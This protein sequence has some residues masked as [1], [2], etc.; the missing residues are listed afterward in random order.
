[1]GGDQEFRFGIFPAWPSTLGFILS[2]L[3]PRD[4]EPVSATPTDLRQPHPG[5]I[6]KLESR[7]RARVVLNDE[8]LR[9]IQG[10][11]HGWTAAPVS[12][13]ASTRL[14]RLVSAYIRRTAREGTVSLH[15]VELDFESRDIR[16]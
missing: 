6:R 3:E 15:L 10:L 13:T 1:M 4:G 9:D 8:R 14:L 5:A 11:L 2:R 16:R 12:D 7:Y